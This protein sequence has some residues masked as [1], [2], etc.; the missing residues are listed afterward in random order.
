MDSQIKLKKIGIN[1]YQLEKIPGMKAEAIVYLKPK[2]VE[3]LSQD[4]SLPQLAEAA[5]LPGVI[6][7]VIGMPDIHE[8]F[9]LPI[10]G[11]MASDEIISAGAVGMDINCGVRLIAT[12]LTYNSK[13]FSPEFLRTIINKIERTIPIGLGGERRSLPP[14]IN[15]KGVVLG[16]A[17]F[18]VQQ[19]YGRQEDLES[20]EENGQLAGA[21]YEALTSRALKRAEKQIG[22]LGSGNHFL[23]IQKVEEIYEPTTAQIWGLKPNQICLMIHCGSRALGHQTCVDYTEIFWRAED[24][25]HLAIPRKGLAAVPID[26][27]EGKNYFA[28]MAGSVNFAFANRQLIMSELERVLTEFFKAK[29]IKVEF[30]LIYDLAHN[31][32]KWEPHRVM[33]NGKWKMENVLVHRKGATRALPAG[34]EKN[35]PKYVKTGHPAIVPG[36]MGTASY[37]LVGLPKAQETWFSVNHGAG[38]AMSRTEAK[39]TISEDEFKKTMGE[40]IYNLPFQKIA[41]EAPGAYKNIEDVVETLVEAGITKKVAKLIPLAVI[42]GD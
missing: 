27:P 20:I 4:L 17:E 2:M 14:K 10:G 11:I 23:E 9:G 35:P 8:G 30:K 19:G 5:M 34:H 33:K 18:L 36:S 3:S 42:K 22:T 29:G 32:A 39:K 13:I 16:G 38:R 1:K 15:L 21:K 40:V 24:K 26:S 31:I 6:S 37:I 28:A 7:P 41:D 25:Y 12:N